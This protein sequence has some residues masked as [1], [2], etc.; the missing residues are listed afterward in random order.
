[1]NS[2]GISLEEFLDALDINDEE[3]SLKYDFL[4][5]LHNLRTSYKGKMEDF[6]KRMK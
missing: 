6:K 2:K 1:M 3:K 5:S 4:Q